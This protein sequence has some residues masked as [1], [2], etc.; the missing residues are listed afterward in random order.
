MKK[1]LFV[2]LLIVF[3]APIARATDSNPDGILNAPTITILGGFQTGSDTYSQWEGSRVYTSHG[4]L[5]GPL[6]TAE[7][8]Y[9]TTK[10]L[11]L[12]F[13]FS[14]SWQKLEHPQSR[15]FYQTE[16]KVSGYGFLFGLRVF[17]N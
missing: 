11:S 10:N 7:I 1:K 15:D 3:T 2:F 4:D 17:G 16:S 8:I 9:P 6:V 14:G 12:I 13:R 5:S